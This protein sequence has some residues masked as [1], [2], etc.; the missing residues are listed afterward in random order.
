M[1]PYDPLC[2]V[3]KPQGPQAERAAK[4]CVMPLLLGG[5]LG[6]PNMKDG[7]LKR[8]LREWV[9]ATC[10]KMTCDGA[11]L[12]PPLCSAQAPGPPGRA[13]SRDVRDA[14]A[15]G[16]RA[17]LA[18]HEGRLLEAIPARM[19]ACHVYQDERPL[20]PRDHGPSSSTASGF[21]GTLLPCSPPPYA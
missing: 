11:P 21:S 17:G 8:Y 18:Q 2:A 5:V 6:S 14:A 19:G 20:E 3:L 10:T 16:G 13:C 7:Y 15:A 4:T 9:L 12:C 1:V